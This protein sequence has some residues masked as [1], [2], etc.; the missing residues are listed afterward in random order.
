M[1][2][3]MGWVPR[4]VNLELLTEDDINVSTK[5]E[6]HA[7]TRMLVL[8]GF[9]VRVKKYKVGGKIRV[10]K[11]TKVGTKIVRKV[12]LTKWKRA[13]AWCAKDAGSWKTNKK[14]QNQPFD[15]KY[16]KGDT[17][18]KGLC[19]LAHR[20]VHS[21]PA[22]PSPSPLPPHPPRAATTV[23][24][25]AGGSASARPLLAYRSG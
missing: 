15:D 20:H 19:A 23:V 18:G 25:D 7:L 2:A 16:T 11:P 5:A 1:A 24:P 9:G 17:F 10:K 4:G 8:R 3:N 6:V 22:I 14:V 12:M 21:C 13:E